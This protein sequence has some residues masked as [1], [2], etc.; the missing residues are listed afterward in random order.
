M[1]GNHP[2]RNANS[3]AASPTAAQVRKARLAADL[4]PQEAGA[5]VY[6]RSQRWLKFENGEARMHPAVWELFN[7]K[8]SQRLG[9][10]LWQ[11][12]AAEGSRA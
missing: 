11:A 6:E 1:T 3:M 2:N 9:L 5:L 7:V 12:M 8:L 10:E 4:T